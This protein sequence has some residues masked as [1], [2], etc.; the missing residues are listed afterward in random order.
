M[1]TGIDTRWSRGLIDAQITFG[2]LENRFPRLQIDHSFTVGI[3]N[4]D[5]SYV[6]IG[7]GF[8]TGSTTDALTLS[9]HH[10]SGRMFPVYRSGRTTDQTYGVDTVHAGCGHHQLCMTVTFPNE[11][12]ISIMCHSTSFDT[13]ITVS[14]AVQIDYHRLVT[15]DD[16]AI[17]KEVEQ[18]R[19]NQTLL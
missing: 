12:G 11:A 19:G 7:T 4:L 16:P 8:N 2:C 3:L 13:I 18:L 1:W 5:G 9:N 14:A 10:I 15:V 17:E 6:V